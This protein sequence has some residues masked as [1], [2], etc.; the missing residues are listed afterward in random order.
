[1]LPNHKVAGASMKF[2]F[3]GIDFL[4]GVFGCSA[5]R[6]GSDASPNIS[7]FCDPALDARRR[8]ALADPDGGAELAAID[9]I[10]TEQAPAV[11]LFNPRYIDVVSA[12]VGHVGYHE[13][14][15]WLVGQSWVQ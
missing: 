4:G 15:R 10:V 6:P 12:R 3:A 2:A 11:V 13:Q 7:G 14:F 9:R 5:F 8:A 1:M